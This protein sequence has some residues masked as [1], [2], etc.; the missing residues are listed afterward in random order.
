MTRWSVSEGLVVFAGGLLLAACSTSE[1]LPPPPPPGL[2][3]RPVPAPPGRG[4]YAFGRFPTPLPLSD[5]EAVL[6]RT[7]VFSFG[8]MPPK[9]QV[10]AFNVLVEQPDAA[11]RFGAV[12]DAASPVARLYAFAGLLL[13]AP[14]AADRLRVEL[15]VDDTAVQ[16]NSSD[17]W[18]RQSVRQLAA[19][20]EERQMGAAFVRARDETNEDYASR[21]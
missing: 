6:R 15:L 9:R 4:D 1:P 19:M 11:E 5:A 10:Q 13:L 16:V 12:A 2:S 7:R 20:I 21:Q 3:E 14:T 17:T 8:G 18:G